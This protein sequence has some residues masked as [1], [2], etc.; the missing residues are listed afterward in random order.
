M[1]FLYDQNMDQIKHE[2]FEEIP[3]QIDRAIFIMFYVWGL[4]VAEVA[5]AFKVDE[6][7]IMGRLDATRTMLQ[8]R[9]LHG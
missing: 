3:N 1:G 7:F 9:F 5:Y 8:D 4:T 2:V 6:P